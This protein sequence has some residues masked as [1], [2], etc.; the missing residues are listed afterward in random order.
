M[1]CAGPVEPSDV[2]LFS[3]D[4]RGER[5]GDAV[6]QHDEEGA[7]LLIL[8][9]RIDEGL[10]DQAAQVNRGPRR[11]RSPSGRASWS[12]CRRHGLSAAIA[13]PVESTGAHRQFD[14]LCTTAERHVPSSLARRL[15]SLGQPITIQLEP[16]LVRHRDPHALEP[17][18][19][20]LE[21]WPVRLAQDIEPE[22]HHEIRADAQ[23]VAIE[24]RMVELA[25][26]DAIGDDGFSPRVAVWQ[27]VGRLEQL[28][29][30]KPADRASLL[31]RPQ[32]PLPERLLVRVTSWPE[33]SAPRVGPARVG[34]E[35][36]A[37]ADAAG[38]GG[39]VFHD[40]G[41]P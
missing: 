5:A 13:A 15:V 34:D 41:G 38:L 6:L 27:D 3:D 31:I 36:G 35:L 1:G 20:V 26:R 19:P 22:V 29:V 21:H 37:A 11:A 2:D 9:V 30:S 40:E 8:A 4:E 39:A 23:D 17:L 24:G 7:V 25:E 16:R 18:E 33:S 14:A 32:H 28:P 12:S 10:L